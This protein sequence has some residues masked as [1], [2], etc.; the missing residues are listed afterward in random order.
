MKYHRKK[1]KSNA[2]YVAE[3]AMKGAK[4]VAKEAAMPKGEYAGKKLMKKMSY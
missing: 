1:K 3:K 4:M 2:K